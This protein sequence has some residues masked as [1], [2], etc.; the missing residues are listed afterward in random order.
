MARG[1]RVLSPTFLSQRYSR[2]CIECLFSVSLHF[3]A[4]GR[5]LYLVWFF[6][7][8]SLHGG[9]LGYTFSRTSVSGWNQR[10]S[11]SQGGP[12]TCMNPHSK[13]CISFTLVKT[14]RVPVS[15]P[16]VL[17]RGLEGSWAATD[18]RQAMQYLSRS[19]LCGK[20][21]VPGSSHAAPVLSYACNS[22][23]NLLVQK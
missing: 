16:I 4:V 14:E 9:N 12:T 2:R 7:L 18:D 8:T 21:R 6:E 10:N 13:Q 17:A 20:K 5:S 1:K 23:Q 19:V 3:S 15:W 22:S 11:K